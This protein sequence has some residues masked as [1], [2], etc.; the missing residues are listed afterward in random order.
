MIDN[1][2]SPQNILVQFNRLLSLYNE[3]KN[4][5]SVSDII[6]I[7]DMKNAQLASPNIPGLFVNGLRLDA[8]IQ[9]EL[10]NSLLSN[11]DIMLRKM[12]DN[13]IIINDEV[14]KKYD[15]YNKIK[16]D[17]SNTLD[18]SNAFEKKQYNIIYFF[19]QKNLEYII[20]SLKRQKIDQ[21]YNDT[22]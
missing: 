6:S 22:N 3:V 18:V 2:S 5:S 16:N 8:L 19:L 13:F 15:I 4:E 17:S 20:D 12:Y 11:T 7:S 1:N 21:F 14:C 10:D 9:S